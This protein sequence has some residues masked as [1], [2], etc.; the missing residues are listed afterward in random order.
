MGNFKGKSPHYNA[1]VAHAAEIAQKLQAKFGE[2]DERMVWKVMMNMVLPPDNPN[3]IAVKAYM[4]NEFE[5]SFY[6]NGGGNTYDSAWMSHTDAK[7]QTVV[8][9]G[10]KLAYSRNAQQSNNSTDEAIETS[11][12]ALQPGM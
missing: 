5:K 7:R 1:F 2:V 4:P 6:D 10:I 3:F 8:A 11:A 12:T 9:T